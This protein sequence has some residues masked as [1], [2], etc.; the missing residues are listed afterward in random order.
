[1]NW[2]EYNDEPYECECG[3]KAP[4]RGALCRRCEEFERDVDHYER[5][6]Y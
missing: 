1:M 4:Y 2:N 5:Y 3:R 6:G